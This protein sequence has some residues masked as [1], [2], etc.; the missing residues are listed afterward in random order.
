MVKDVTDITNFANPLMDGKG[1]DER[2]NIYLRKDYLPSSDKHSR[3]M[4]FFLVVCLC[5]LLHHRP[6][7]PGSN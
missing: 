3:R 7:R 1:C 5:Y 4:V 6:G 2:Q